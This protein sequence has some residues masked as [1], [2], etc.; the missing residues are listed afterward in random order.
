MLGGAA[1]HSEGFI[2]YFLK[3]PLACLGSMAA[4]VQPNSLGT[5]RKHLT[6]PLEQV[7]APRSI[8]SDYEIR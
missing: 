1:T 4:A 8:R 6:K 7:A 2:T 5:L 3:V